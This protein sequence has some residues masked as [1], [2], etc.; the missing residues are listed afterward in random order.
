MKKMNFDKLTVKQ[1]AGAKL[2]FAPGDT[3]LIRTVTMIL[4]GRLRAI[5]RDFFVLEDGVVVMSNL[6]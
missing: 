2:P 4:L 6:R 1:P 5:G 3:L